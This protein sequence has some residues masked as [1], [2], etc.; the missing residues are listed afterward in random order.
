MYIT[1]KKIFA[2]IRNSFD[3]PKGKLE[4]LIS[5][6]LE[7]LIDPP[8]GP[9]LLGELIEK[10][11]EGVKAEIRKYIEDCRS[12]GD[13]PELEFGF[14]SSILIN[15]KYV[16]R[17]AGQ[18]FLNWL[19]NLDPFKFEALCKKILELE[20][21]DNVQVT[22]PSGDGGIDF[23]GT[24][25]IMV[26]GNDNPIVFR[27]VE[28]LVIGQAK[29]YS[30]P[31]DIAE[32]RSFI[33]SFDLI[34]IAGLKTAPD[35]LPNVIGEGVSFRPLSPILLLFITSS[36]PNATAKQVARWLGI[37]IIS[38]KELIDILY[39]NKIGFSI[40]ESGVKFNPDDLR[41]L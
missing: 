19:S 11:E 25:K 15:K 29:R 8:P 6:V 30:Y 9:V 10:H 22:P 5:N 41:A 13:F 36:E 1:H 21:C 18:E 37:R 12:S 32:L 2:Y 23:F 4:D 14:S 31:I 20:G 16:I 24:K 26:P 34:K 39:E 38:G 40:Y 28:L 7:Q 17:E 33:G 3:S 35:C 27:N